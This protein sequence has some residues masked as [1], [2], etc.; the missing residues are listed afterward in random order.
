MTDAF[1][2]L[3]REPGPR[4][5]G[6][7]AVDLLRAA[8]MIAERAI[9]FVRVGIGIAVAIFFFVVVSPTMLPDNP[10]LNLV[11]VFAVFTVGYVSA[12]VVSR[13]LARPAWFRPWMTWLFTTVDLVFWF[14][15]LLAIVRVIGMPGAY[16]ILLPP[17]LLVFALLALAALR[18][19]PWLQAYVLSFSVLALLTVH[20]T[21]P[22][23]A[24]PYL[25]GNGSTVGFFEPPFSVVRLAMVVLT[26]AILVVLGVRTRALLDR[27]IEETVRRA[28]LARYLPQQVAGRLAGTDVDRL[29]AG[30]SGE[31]AILFVDIRGF[32]SLA[33]VM[34]PRRLS[35]FLA[36][37]R[38]IVSERVHAHG[39]LVDKFVGDSVMAVFG[40]P[41]RGTRDAADA[42]DC[43]RAI[44]DSIAQWSERRRRS[45][46]EP[47]HVGIGVHSGDVFCGA[48][49]DETRLEFTVLGDAVNVA[50]RLEKMSK[51]VGMPIVASQDVLS[52]AGIGKPV[53]AGWTPVPQSTVRGRDGRLHIMAHPGI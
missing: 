12:G 32:T 41:E 14:G 6:A 8:E 40:A 9:A 28:N 42:V 38:R 15:L 23:I 34:D 16:L 11:P 1:A 17:V 37:Y 18:N 13:V 44:V 21:A 39:G 51:E 3:E 35:G 49:G 30:A 10:A 27:A 50:A 25:T 31:A 22:E 36:E 2:S 20:F 33:E 26:G 24:G 45:G 7:E 5:V 46:H 47:V 4:A 29:L 52:A 19:N 53:E 48:V 43:A